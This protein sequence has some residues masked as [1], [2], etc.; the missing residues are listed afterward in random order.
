MP[1]VLS[2]SLLRGSQALRFIRLPLP[3]LANA[4]SGSGVRLQFALF[5]IELNTGRVERAGRRV[6]L[7]CVFV[8]C[9]DCGLKV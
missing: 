8:P 6:Y 1:T 5:R 9:L 3:S 7:I 4:L 2:L